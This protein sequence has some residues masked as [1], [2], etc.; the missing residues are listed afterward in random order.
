MKHHKEARELIVSVGAAFN[1]QQIAL[2]LKS[3]FEEIALAVS[4]PE[5]THFS[6]T[7]TPLRKGSKSLVKAGIIYNKEVDPPVEPEKPKKKAN[8]KKKVIPISDHPAYVNH[9]EDKPKKKK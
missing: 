4:N 5:A 8:A 3:V 1:R 6:I 9:G 2:V 7:I